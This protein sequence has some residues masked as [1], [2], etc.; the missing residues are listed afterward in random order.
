MM[1]GLTEG[2]RP[3]LFIKKPA[4]IQVAYIGYPCT[5]GQ[6]RMDYIITDPIASP[7]EEAYL[8]S[9]KLA[10]LKGYCLFNYQIQPTAP[11]VAPA[12]FI[13]N[14]FVTFGSYNSLRKLSKSTID[15]WAT[16]LKLHQSTRLVLKSLFFGDNGTRNYVW[17]RF[18]E[19]GVKR[20]RIDLE[21]A[22]Y[23]HDEF[24]ET[25]GKIDIALDTFPYNGA[26]TTAEAL[27]MGVPVITLTGR[28]LYGRMT[29]SILYH[30][31]LHQL[32][33]KT[34]DEYI[35]IA[36]DFVKYP[37]KIITQ[38]TQM[39]DIILHSGLVDGVGFT[40]ELERLYKQMITDFKDT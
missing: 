15:L 13:K 27:W 20:S 39:R 18:E 2:G 28:H 19:K 29:T 9:E 16:I 14:G 36:S 38:R 17:E 23:Q 4:P 40:K 25:Y 5:T 30:A 33:A 37:A 6:T 31:K 12:P 11:A 32:I 7:S 10:Y 3:Y 1:P 8:Y 24:L 21:I 35:Q 26:T 22:T 34:R